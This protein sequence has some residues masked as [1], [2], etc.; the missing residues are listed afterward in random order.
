MDETGLQ[1]DDETDR[2]LGEAATGDRV[3]LDRLLARHRARLHRMVDLRMAAQ[4]RSRIDASDVVQ[5]ACIEAA[6][7][8]PQ[9]LEDRKMSFF[10][11][12]RFLTHQRLITLH[13]HH[14]GVKARDPR[15]EISIHRGALPEAT[16]AALASRLLGQLTTPSEAAMR[17]ETEMQLEQALNG[18]DPVER[19]ILALRHFE[20][21]SNAEV[22]AVL[23]LKESAASKRY[24]RALIK[25]KSALARL[26][27]EPR[28]E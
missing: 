5:E 27:L 25:L 10:L 23:E 26:G 9:Y 13:R 21:L 22:A 19:E 18:L 7:R 6:D 15:R 4:L 16:S 17:A 3:A 12:L 24:V 28:T 1:N 8:L 14:V 2:L 20:Q 11:W